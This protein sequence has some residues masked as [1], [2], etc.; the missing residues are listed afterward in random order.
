MI[1]TSGNYSFQDPPF[2]DGDTVTGGNY[3][4]FVPETEICK[5]VKNLTITGGNF[6][7][8]KPQPTW[9]VTGGR[10]CQISRCSH[11]HPE[12]VELGLPECPANCEHRTAEKVVRELDENEVRRRKQ[13]ARPLD[14]YAAT[15]VRSADGVDVIRHTVVEYVYSEAVHEDV[16]PG[17]VVRARA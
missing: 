16:R 3:R 4:M 17:R 9:T 14:G 6:T 8:I 10:W 12:W 5:G 15:K 1:H 11:L 2:K 7:N 13:Q